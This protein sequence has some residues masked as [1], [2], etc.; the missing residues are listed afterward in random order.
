[1]ENTNTFV[2]VTPNIT[3]ALSGIETVELKKVKLEYFLIIK[4]THRK[5]FV[6]SGL[7]MKQ[8]LDSYGTLFFSGSV[9]H[10]ALKQFL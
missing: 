1:M 8:F 4:L 7:D 6:L 2:R 3:A 5:A 10:E 9:I